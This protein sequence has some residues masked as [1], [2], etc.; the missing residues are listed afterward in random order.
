MKYSQ[1]IGILAVG[2]LA[3]SCFMPWAYY[4]DLD[5]T[6]NGFF[7][8]QNQYGKPVKLIIIL[9]SC[10]IIMFLIPKVWAKRWNL[11]FGALIVAYAIKN[12]ITYTGCYSTYCPEK[13]AGIWVMLASSVLVLVMALLPD[14]KVSNKESK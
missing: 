5:K 1:L 10:A 8:E 4:P 13:R 3:G 6:F 7:S 12:F 2:L 14:L 9:G 11:L